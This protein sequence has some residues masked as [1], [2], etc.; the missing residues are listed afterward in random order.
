MAQQREQQ[1]PPWVLYALVAF[2]VV[3]FGVAAYAGYHD[4]QTPD[5]DQLANR[6]YQA[7]FVWAI[8]NALIGGLAA[9]AAWAP[10]AAGSSYVRTFLVDRDVP[11]PFLLAGV[12]GLFGI[13]IFA[14]GM[15][16][17]Y[18]WW[19]VVPGGLVSGREAWKGGPTWQ[20]WRP[21]IALGLIIAGLLVTFFSLV[22]VRSE[23]R[24]YPGLRRMIYGFNTVLT[25]L[26]V[27]AVLGATNVMAFFY[28]Q[29]GGLDPSDWTETQV[30]SVSQE[31]RRI[32]EGLDKP[33]KIYVLLS[34][35]EALGADVR[36]LIANFKNASKQI[37]HDPEEDDINP[38]D[39]L[40]V[41]RLVGRYELSDRRGVLVVYDPES[42]GT[43]KY[44]FLK[45]T[46]LQE[47]GM[48]RGDQQE[49]TFKG[50][51]AIMSAI[52]SLR[53]GNTKQA[54]YFT[55]DSGELS[56]EETRSVR[57]YDIGL[58]NLKLL[59]ERGNIFTPKPLALG[60]EEK[61]PDDAFAV[62]IAG[63]RKPFTLEKIKLLQDYM[64][65]GGKLVVLLDLTEDRQG[66]PTPAATGLEKFLEEYGVQVGHDLILNGNIRQLGQALA[67]IVTVSNQSETSFR[68][69][70]GG[71][72][73]T[74]LKARSVRPS[75]TPGR[76]SHMVSRLFETAPLPLAQWA[77]EK[78]AAVL[79]DLKEFERKRRA[80]AE[81]V[82][83]AVTVR[84]QTS[85]GG[86]FH[87]QGTPR[88]VVFGDATF[89]SNRDIEEQPIQYKILTSSLSW[90]RDRPDM[91]S[92]I[93]PKT[94]KSYRVTITPEQKGSIV[95]LPGV[96]L[97]MGILACGA[98][99]W[100][101]R[102]R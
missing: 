74:F 50:E 1:A 24:N 91:I 4:R 41:A 14:L 51:Q 30:Y 37:I 17:A 59:L 33:V 53:E 23:E 61:V 6:Q 44:Q 15:G 76:G 77:E 45:P 26:L 28:V 90:L 99:V 71:V 7:L 56:L 82:P 21:Y 55:Q 75:T 70:F 67:C 29:Q 11:A 27:F 95:L 93:E 54:V 58:G 88:M 38:D 47:E 98:G 32:L 16:Y 43:K 96:L 81:P 12:G 94:R 63:P 20:H 66:L 19:D 10:Q 101:I 92:A 2:T 13:T 9:L 52:V 86:E 46:E 68:E 8:F 83:V 89:L 36:M 60:G 5:D 100:L 102:R 87:A 34:P 72:G 31:S 40:T 49:R 25:G 42:E 79:D 65:R 22:A 80:R 48:G 39:I 64:A 97:M 78:P 85:P 69:G 84:D 35:G 18:F 3:M 57:Q 62:V 73:F